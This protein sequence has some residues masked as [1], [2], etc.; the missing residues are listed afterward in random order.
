MKMSQCLS[1]KRHICECEI[2]IYLV[3]FTGIF[4]EK[5][6]MEFLSKLTALLF[7][8]G[9]AAAIDAN[10]EELY[11]EEYG[12]SEYEYGEYGDEF[13]SE[14]YEKYIENLINESENENATERAIGSF[15]TGPYYKKFV[16]SSKELLRTRGLWEKKMVMDKD[17]SMSR[18]TIKWS[19][20]SR[21]YWNYC[22]EGYKWYTYRQDGDPN[23]P[24][25]KVFVADDIPAPEEFYTT[26]GSPN[27]TENDIIKD[28]LFFG[29]L[30]YGDAGQAFFFVI[31]PKDWRPYQ[32]R[33]K[34]NRMT[35]F[36][37]TAI[38]TGTWSAV[39]ATAGAVLGSVIP[40]AG[41]LAGGAIGA[42]LG[43]ALSSQVDSYF[44]DYLRYIG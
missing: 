38:S 12:S 24:K 19:Q 21:C 4:R 36:F 25:V 6:V 15:T 9:V 26:G 28:K 33:F 1:A 8:L 3:Y 44:G 11:G 16:E 18:E 39:G 30:Y 10:S 2:H 14:E 27:S 37:N 35:E 32:K 13:N 5:L 42:G 20:W 22:T 34:T 29:F 17:L 43:A 41:T 40:G 31:H 23:N 7:F